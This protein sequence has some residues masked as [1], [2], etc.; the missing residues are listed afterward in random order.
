MFQYT[1]VS[2]ASLVEKERGKRKGEGKSGYQARRSGTPGGDQ[3]MSTSQGHRRLVGLRSWDIHPLRI[4][5][6]CGYP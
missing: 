6:T 3:G 1:F 4:G 2:I 5:D